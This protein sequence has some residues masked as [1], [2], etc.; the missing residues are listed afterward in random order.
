MD[1]G[2]NP[3][4]PLLWGYLVGQETINIDLITRT[5]R[6]SESQRVILVGRPNWNILYMSPL[7]QMLSNAFSTSRKV[8]TTCPP[9]L[10]LSMIDRDSVNR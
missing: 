9:L 8:A 6:E 1:S 5:N 3:A 2:H 7:C 4:E 10:K